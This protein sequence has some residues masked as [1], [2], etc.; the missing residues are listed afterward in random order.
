MLKENLSKAPGI[1]G[2]EEYLNSVILIPLMKVGDEYHFIFEKR[3]KG[4]RQGGEVCFPGGMCDCT[5]DKDIKETAL[6]E[7][8][9]EIGIAPGHI[10]IIGP[11]DTLVAP[12]GVIVDAF[13]G[14]VNIKS[15]DEVVI[16]H[17]EV[18]YAFT[19]PVSYF[20]KSR[21]E[22]YNARVILEPS[23]IDEAGREVVLF[24]SRELGVPEKYTR[25]WGKL[26]YPI[27]LYRVQGELIWGITA[28]FIMDMVKKIR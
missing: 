14:L 16:N 22:M 19:V 27:P 11:M 2:R 15:L 18:E 20:Q 5:R 8:F 26:N 24:P 10:D 25:P 4:I 28:R 9:E 6:R 23:F 12:M 3:S 13:V 7:T 1:L 17:E 21:P